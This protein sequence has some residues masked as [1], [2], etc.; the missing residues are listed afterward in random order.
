MDDAGAFDNCVASIKRYMVDNVSN[1]QLME[2][3]RTAQTF[4]A[5]PV[6]YRTHLYVAG[7]FLGP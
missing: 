4:S 5:F 3:L 1:E 2:E 7:L 6:H